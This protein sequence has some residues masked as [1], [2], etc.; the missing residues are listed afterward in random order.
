M[1]EPVPAPGGPG[2]RLP[3]WAWAAAA[4]GGLVLG[5]FFLR[6]SGVPPEEDAAAQARQVE[7]PGAPGGVA[8]DVL[9]ALGLRPP[10]GDGGGGSSSGGGDGSGGGGGDD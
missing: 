9:E 8:P 4:A 3:L 1:P 6:Q 2:K 10:S 5:Y 7:A